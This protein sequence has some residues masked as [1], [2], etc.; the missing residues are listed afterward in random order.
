MKGIK[1]VNIVSNQVSQ[2][3]GS[4]ESGDRFISLALYQGTPKVDMQ[5]MLARASVT[6]KSQTADEFLSQIQPDPMIFCTR[7]VIP[8]LAR[9]PSSHTSV[10]TRD[11]SFV[12]QSDFQMNQKNHG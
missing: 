9:L 6:G 3:I 7:L 12:F 10:S 1:V 4:S 8:F 11:D 2:I 5:L